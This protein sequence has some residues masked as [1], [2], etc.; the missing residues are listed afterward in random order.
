MA[1]A[2]F[3]NFGTGLYVSINDLALMI[4]TVVG[5]K[6]EIVFYCSKPDGTPRKLMDVSKLKDLGW[7]AQTS[8][9][10]GITKTYDWFQLHYET[11]RGV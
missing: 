8:L 9:K 4:L 1:P 6:G 11:L 10:D 5:Y 7:Q 3:V 2:L